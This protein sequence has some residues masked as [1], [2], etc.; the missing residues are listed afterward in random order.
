MLDL[1]RFQD[2]IQD[3]V[4]TCIVNPPGPRKVPNYLQKRGTGPQNP[5]KDRKRKIKDGK[6]DKGPPRKGTG[7]C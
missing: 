4:S 3:F 2:E 6:I 5:K 7:F 1:Y